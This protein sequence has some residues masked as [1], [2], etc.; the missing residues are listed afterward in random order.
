[1]GEFAANGTCYLRAGLLPASH[2]AARELLRDY[3]DLRLRAAESGNLD[4]AM[5]KSD[6]LHNA[7]WSQAT[8]ASNKDTHSLVTG[9]FVQS[10]N[11]VIDVHAPA[12]ER[13]VSGTLRL[14]PVAVDICGGRRRRAEILTAA[15]TWPLNV[16][17]PLPAVGWA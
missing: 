17:K 3:T 14:S 1:M 9:L 4:E 12:D 15:I 2:A 7:L 8:E 10:L 6:E 11:E 5:A 16:Q 13:H